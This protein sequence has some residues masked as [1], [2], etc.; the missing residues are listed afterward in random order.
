MR[1]SDGRNVRNRADRWASHPPGGGTIGAMR[2]PR[3]P[4]RP[5]ALARAAALPLAA[6]LLLGTTACSGGSDEGS[7]AGADAAASSAPSPSTT[8]RSVPSEGPLDADQACAAMYVSGDE[9]LER[10]VGQALLDVKEGLSSE[11]AMQMHTVGTE[12]GELQT[13]VPEE[14]AAALEKVRVPFVQLQTEL[15]A[16]SSTSVELDVASATEGLKEY[17]ALC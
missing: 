2:A 12:L 14:F 4:R 10:R 13:R 15:D 8:V 1:R 5:R 3:L 17:R 6:A 11:T 7:G 9:Q 16:A